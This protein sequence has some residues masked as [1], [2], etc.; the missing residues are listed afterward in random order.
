MPMPIPMTP[1]PLCHETLPPVEKTSIEETKREKWERWEKEKK[2]FIRCFYKG[3]IA[4]EYCSRVEEQNPKTGKFRVR[5]F[6]SKHIP[7]ISM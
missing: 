1:T 5:W 6:C 4:N 3:C 2:Q 7:A